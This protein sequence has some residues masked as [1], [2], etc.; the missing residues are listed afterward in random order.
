MISKAAHET[1]AAGAAVGRAPHAAAR[2]LETC[3]GDAPLLLIAPHGGRAGAAA[4]AAL[5]PKVND[6]HTAEITRELSARLGAGAIINRAMDRNRLDLNRLSQVM[7]AAPWMLELI[8]ERLERLAARHR[9]ATVL[10]V[11]GWNVIEPRVDLGVGLKSSGDTLRP[12][13]GAHLSASDGFIN[14][15]L[16]D[17]SERL[18]RDGILAS[19]GLRYPGGGANNLLQAFTQRHA[20]SPLGALRRLAALSARGALEAVQLELSVALRMPGRLRARTLDAIAQTFGRDQSPLTPR[21]RRIVVVHA[22]ETRAPLA[23]SSATALRLAQPVAAASPLRVGLE[24]YDPMA[25]VGAMASFD[26]GP[27]A[28]GARVMALVGRER[29][30]LFTAEGRVERTPHRL[31]LGP[32]VLAAD[33]GRLIFEFRG[34]AVVVDDGH[35]YLSVEQALARATLHDAMELRAE[36]V[37]WSQPERAAASDG[38]AL[39]EM[40]AHPERSADA[41]FGRVTGRFGLAGTAHPID[42]VA[43][44]GRSFTGVGGGEFHARRMVWAAFPGAGAPRALETRAVLD[45]GGKHRLDARLLDCD[46]WAPR[47]AQ[48]IVLTPAASRRPPQ[49]IAARLRT[50]ASGRAEPLLAGEVHSFVMLSRPG[51]AQSRILTTLG[52]ATF[53]LGGYLGAGMF[54]R[55]RRI[56]TRASGANAEIGEDD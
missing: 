27:G 11:H 5:H 36:F 21:R 55:S 2:W 54:E 31:A 26:L 39:L 30:A 17:L 37:P 24:F 44:A 49:R 43:R 16:L 34:P 28:A 20:A 7:E 40:L 9:H 41:A 53:R 50:S 51:P 4:R 46:G 42:A 29:I 14:G 1:G 38:A 32:L 12:A 47:E 33:G 19:F 45:G 8:A 10:L 3:E 6:L 25:Q 22:G 56:R 48:S 23:Q 15:A 52:F 35:A 13:R 18:R